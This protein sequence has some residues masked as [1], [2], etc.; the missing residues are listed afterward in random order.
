MYSA[1]LWKDFDFKSNDPYEVCLKEWF[2]AND[3]LAKEMNILEYF[4]L[5][6][7][8]ESHQYGY[9]AC[10]IGDFK[11]DNERGADNLHFGGIIETLESFENYKQYLAIKRIEF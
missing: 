10:L 2:E 8:E 6:N 7:S 1:N 11:L 9:G 4:K 5:I 3:I